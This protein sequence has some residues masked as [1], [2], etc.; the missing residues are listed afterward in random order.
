MKT[1]KSQKQF[2]KQEIIYSAI[3]EK[4]LLHNGLVQRE[5]LKTLR[6]LNET[7]KTLTVI[8]QDFERHEFLEIHKSKWKIILYNI[9]L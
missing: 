9:S 4:E 5:Q 2:N 1:E 3:V 8:L 6:E 7:M